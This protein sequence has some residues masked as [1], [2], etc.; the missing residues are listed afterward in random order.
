MLLEVIFSG[1]QN[2]ANDETDLEVLSN[3]WKVNPNGN[4]KL[5]KDSLVPNSRKFKNLEVLSASA[6]ITQLIALPGA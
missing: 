4:T 1:Q 2:L 6:Q 5:L 3:A